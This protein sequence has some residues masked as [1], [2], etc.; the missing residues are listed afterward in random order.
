MSTTTLGRRGVG[1]PAG[2]KRTEI[3]QTYLSPAEQ[4]AVRA[5]A[6][7]RGR[8]ISRLM[9]EVLLSEV[10]KQRRR[11]KFEA[12]LDALTP[13]EIEEINRDY[14]SGESAEWMDAPMGPPDP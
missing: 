4:E 6:A 13:E 7:K 2:R 8:T 3:V 5:L 12:S 11:E 9:R 10:E 14:A 1:R